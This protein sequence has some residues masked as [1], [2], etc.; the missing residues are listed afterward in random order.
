[1]EIKELM[2]PLIIHLVLRRPQTV[3]NYIIITFL[4]L[5]LSKSYH[6]FFLHMKKS[7]LIL[8]IAGFL[9]IGLSEIQAQTTQPKLD[10]LELLK[11][12]F[13]T[14][15]YELAKDTTI[16]SEFTPFGTAIEDN[17]QIV[18]KGKILDSGNELLGYDKNSDRIITA[19]LSKSSPNIEITSWC[20]TS[21]NIFEGVMF[22]DI[23]NP[24]NATLIMKIEFKSP[25]LFVL[26]FTQ[27][28]KV[29]A[30]STYTREKR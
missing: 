14:W 23:S 19:R 13:G 18:T 4:E 6:I 3:G 25:D 2:T 9:V 21:K 15:K 8:V 12:F 24:P 16:I 10:Q 29:V 7:L 17:Y 30:T 20:W 11:Q 26:R 1:M 27:N 28:N 5:L 22:Q